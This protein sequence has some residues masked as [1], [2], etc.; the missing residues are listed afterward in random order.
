[1]ATVRRIRGSL[2]SSFDRTPEPRP[3]EKRTTRTGLPE[4]VTSDATGGI[5]H[6]AGKITVTQVP[7]AIFKD[8]GDIVGAVGD[9]ELSFVRRVLGCDLPVHGESRAGIGPAQAFRVGAAAAEV[10]SHW[11]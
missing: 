11:R 3:P 6:R 2:T 4:H 1:M 8:R 5:G 9:L 7:P 10:E